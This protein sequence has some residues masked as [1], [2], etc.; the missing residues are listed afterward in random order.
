[1]DPLSAAGAIVGF[2]VPVFQCAKA[3]RDRIKLVCYLSYAVRGWSVHSSCW[4]S[5]VASEKSELLVVLVEYEKDINLLE[6]LYNEHK[7]L[8][9]QHHLDAD[10]KELEQCARS[11]PSPGGSDG[12]QGYSRP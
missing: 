7:A 3:V 10:L 8:L 9:D 5:Q 1:M 12:T 11:C 6:S 4:C 2:A